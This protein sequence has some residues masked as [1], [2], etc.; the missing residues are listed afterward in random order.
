MAT[1]EGVCPVFV[2]VQAGPKVVL[3]KVVMMRRKE[4]TFYDLNN[5]LLMKHSNGQRWAEDDITKIELSSLTDKNEK[6]SVSKDSMS[7]PLSTGINIGLNMITFYLDSNYALGFPSTSNIGKEKNAFTLLL[8]S[9]YDIPGKVKENNQYD[10][11]YNEL[12]DWVNSK[13]VKWQIEVMH[14]AERLLRCLRNCLWYLESGFEK[15][16]AQGCRIPT[17]FQKY[18]D[19]R[20]WK[21]LKKSPPKIEAHRLSNFITELTTCLSLPSSNTKSCQNIVPS[22]ESLLE[23]MIKYMDHL[24]MD[25]TKNAESRLT[26]VAM[27][28]EGARDNTM[29]NIASTKYVNA[30]YEKLNESLKQHDYYEVV[31]L[32]DYCPEG[33]VERRAFIKKMQQSMDVVLYR[34]AYGGA[35]GTHSFM[36]KVPS[37]DN[38]EGNMKVLTSISTMLPKYTSRAMKKQFLDKYTKHVNVPKYMLRNMFSELTGTEPSPETSDQARINERTAEFL[39][40]SHDTDILLDHRENNGNKG[41]TKFLDFYEGVEKYFERQIMAVQERRHGEELYSITSFI[42]PSW[43]L[44][45]ILGYT[46]VR[47]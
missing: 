36:W 19:Y 45:I 21:A 4:E 41:N 22:I 1:T 37:G 13:G 44:M 20:N 9:K 31:N 14:S 28:D 26:E 8:G 33:I 11:M 29:T 43:D 18:K 34:V 17:A 38:I 3:P 10:A 12:R 40:S 30:L 24:K 32:S 39:L 25:S 16:E 2:A 7:L 27:E 23:S 35:I 5:V 15:L 6:I 46:Y 47:I 42:R